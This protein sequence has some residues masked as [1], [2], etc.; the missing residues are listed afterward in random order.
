MVFDPEVSLR[1]ERT[2]CEA[3]PKAWRTDSPTYTWSAKRLE[4]FLRVSTEEFKSFARLT[5]N[6]DV[7]KL[8]IDDLCTISSEISD[9]TEIGHV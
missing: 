2:Q 4:N 3:D 7:H 1:A 8:S 9:N 6:H 5:G